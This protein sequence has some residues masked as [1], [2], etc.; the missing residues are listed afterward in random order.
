M[1]E[2]ELQKRLPEVFKGY[3][4]LKVF[5]H[6]DLT[7]EKCQEELEQVREQAHIV[8]IDEAHHFRNTG[9]KGEAEGE[10]RSR[11]WRL[12]DILEGKQIYHLTATPINNSLLDFQHMVELF[13]RHQADYFSAA[14]LGIHSL[15]GHVRQLENSIE[16]QLFG[17]AR[18]LAP[19]ALRPG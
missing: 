15:A 10:R 1:W 3:S 16:R 4:R 12:Y 14:P 18:R 5:S 19:V 9:T 2:R 17:A 13:S 7:R 8:I 11:Y 6:T